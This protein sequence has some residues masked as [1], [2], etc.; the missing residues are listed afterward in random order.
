MAGLSPSL[1]LTVDVQDGFRLNKTYKQV[2]QQNFTNLLLTIPGERIMDPEFGVGLKTYLFEMDNQMLRSDLS[3][4]IISQAARY[5]P[6]IEITDI[7]F[8][9]A[10][11]DVD[12]QRN[13][14]YASIT[15][16]ITPLEFADTLDISLPDN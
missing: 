13:T 1:P 14:M 10:E 2:V 16:I 9:T 6:F 7:T 15:Y 3:A 11:T 8:R 12:I 4:K 5:L